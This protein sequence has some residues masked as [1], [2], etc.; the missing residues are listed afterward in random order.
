MANRTKK[1]KIAQ[2]EPCKNISEQLAMQNP[3][4][5]IPDSEIKIENIIQ[6]SPSFVP[7]KIKTP[8]A[9]GKGKGV[10]DIKLNNNNSDSEMAQMKR[11]ETAEER[12]ERLKKE[13]KNRDREKCRQ[14]KW[15][16]PPKS[17]KMQY[18]KLVRPLINS[19]LQRQLTRVVEEVVKIAVA[20]PKLEN[21]I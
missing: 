20:D 19:W 6:D 8:K 4:T 18:Q 15:Q 21:P 17:Q 10:E 12:K 13:K 7:Y 11:T 16:R 2:K 1:A 5:K 9:R 14:T 3:C